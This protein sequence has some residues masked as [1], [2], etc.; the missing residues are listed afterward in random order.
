M[1]TQAM[2]QTFIGGDACYNYIDEHDL[3][4]SDVCANYSEQNLNVTPAKIYQCTICGCGSFEPNSPSLL[5]LRQ[6]C[7]KVQARHNILKLMRNS[8]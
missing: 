7:Q 2:P 3:T 5:T 8:R 1:A 4:V 6:M